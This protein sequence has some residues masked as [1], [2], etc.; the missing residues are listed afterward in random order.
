MCA[1]QGNME[2]GE[3]P[4]DLIPGRSAANVEIDARMTKLGAVV[5]SPVFGK[6]D[7][8]L[9]SRKEVIAA[10]RSRAEASVIKVSACGD[11]AAGESGS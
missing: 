8:G 1:G 5:R 4:E 9:H 10:L 6:T 2:Q 3:T 11:R 7:E